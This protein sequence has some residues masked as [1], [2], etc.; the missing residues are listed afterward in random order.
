MFESI[1][2]FFGG[3]DKEKGWQGILAAALGL[4]AGYDSYKDAKEAQDAYRKRPHSGY[5]GGIPDYSVVREQVPMTGDAYDATR[6]PGSSGRRYFTDSEYVGTP[7]YEQPEIAEQA[8]GQTDEAYNTYVAGLH[9]QAR[10]NQQNALNALVEGAQTRA[11]TQKWGL[12]AANRAN[13]Y[14]QTLPTPNYNPTVQRNVTTL[15]TPT[16][17]K[18]IYDVLDRLVTSSQA[19]PYGTTTTVSDTEDVIGAAGGG[20]MGMYLGGRTDGMADQIP[21]RI[22]GRQEARLSDGEYVVPADVVS[23]L[24]NGNSDA[25]AKV[26]KDMMGRV[27]QARTGTPKQGKE[28]NPNKIL[29]AQVLLCQQ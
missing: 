25:G 13:P 16:A 9:E 12:A 15:P 29:P 18:S 10:E 27:R 1:L 19:T 3:G 24:G 2:K 8:E 21:A 20:L 14:R 5:Q 23:H 17:H 28:I 4:G 22:D 26:L 7:A 6:R 11:D